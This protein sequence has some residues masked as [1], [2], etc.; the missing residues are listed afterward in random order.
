MFVAS[1]FCSCIANNKLLNETYLFKIK[2]LIK[3]FKTTL[4]NVQFYNVNA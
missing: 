1:C 3:I 2:R 4:F